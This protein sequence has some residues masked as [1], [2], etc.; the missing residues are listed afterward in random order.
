MPTTCAEIEERVIEACKDLD[1]QEHP[2][3]AKTA[4]VFD[5]PDGRLRR[6]FLN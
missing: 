1:Q 2:N 6:R 3:I 5:V 4:R